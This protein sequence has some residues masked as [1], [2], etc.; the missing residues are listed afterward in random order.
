MGD[1]LYSRLHRIGINKEEF[2]MGGAVAYIDFQTMWCNGS[3]LSDGAY[4]CGFRVRIYSNN[5]P[6]EVTCFELDLKGTISEHTDGG[7]R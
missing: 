2:I 6:I 5:N 7:G 1:T 4:F 3:N